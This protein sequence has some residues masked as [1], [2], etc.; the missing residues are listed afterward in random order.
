M[1]KG[2]MTFTLIHTSYN[3][4]YAISGKISCDGVNKFMS[5]D[6]WT[7]NRAVNQNIL[8]KPD[9]WRQTAEM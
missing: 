7:E 3:K 4:N 9:P 2:I 5:H 8:F 1:W 6:K